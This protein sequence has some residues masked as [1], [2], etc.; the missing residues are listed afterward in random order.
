MSDSNKE[1]L[2]RVKRF[3]LGELTWAEVEVFTSE[4]AREVGEHAC[5]LARAGRLGEAQVLL[6]GLTAVNPRDAASHAA[7]GTV[8]DVTL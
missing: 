8:Y 4:Q 7:L 2:E 3:V 6:E 1:A 5:A